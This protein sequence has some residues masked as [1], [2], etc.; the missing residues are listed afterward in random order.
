[1]IQE[2]Q[3]AIQKAAGETPRV[4]RNPIRKP[5]FAEC[6][7]KKREALK[8]S[9]TSYRATSRSRGEISQR[10]AIFNLNEG[11]ETVINGIETRLVVWPGVGATES[12][13]HVLTVQPG[14]E[15]DSYAL[16]MSDEAMVC[17]SGRGEV[18]V[19]GQWA[20]IEAGDVAYFPAGIRHAVRNTKANGKNFILASCI[21][22][23]NLD[24]YTGTGF[25][26]AQTRQFNFDVIDIAVK[27]AVARGSKFGPMPPNE[28]HLN[29]SHPDLR[30]WNL[31][32]E[33]VRANGG[34]FNIYKG[35]KS[36]VVIPLR[37]ILWPGHGGS[38]LVGYNC[39]VHQPKQLF[40]I[41][42]HPVSPERI[43]AVQGTGLFYLE[44]AWIEARE[45]DVLVAP[46]GVQHGTAGSEKTDG[47]FVCAGFATPPQL[48][49]ILASGFY[50]D[51]E[52]VRP[53][54]E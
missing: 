1:M 26:S 47:T 17:L 21:S 30:A 40:D 42:V 37:L 9:H 20:E 54:F 15:S 53:P 4:S 11:V 44:D 23:P 29:E 13:V 6:Y 36:P 32:T 35:A 34:L 22:P 8:L 33:D 2:Y 24:L 3:D 10:G 28:T 16:G 31:E 50:K 18:F 43:I 38:A 5:W 25:I 41:H 49:L 27:N 48:D 51:G 12:S 7:G 14:D 46:S 45:N 52:F 39:V 19:R